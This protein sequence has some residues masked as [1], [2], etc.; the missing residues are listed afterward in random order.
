MTRL[1]KELYARYFLA[2][3][4][5]TYDGVELYAQTVRI[6]SD[7]FIRITKDYN[8]IT[9]DF[10]LDMKYNRFDIYERDEYDFNGEKYIDRELYNKYPDRQFEIR[11]YHDGLRI[12]TDENNN[13]LFA[14][15]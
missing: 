15:F 7:Q 2:D 5:H 9:I 1:K 3:K 12:F 6:Y 4:H 8:V 10:L 13:I 14:D 11:E